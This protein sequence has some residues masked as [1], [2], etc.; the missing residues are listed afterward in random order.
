VIEWGGLQLAEQVHAELSLLFDKVW[1]QDDQLR[2]L[3]AK[4]FELSA[5]EVILANNE[6]D[7]WPMSS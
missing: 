2:S 6:I 1:A 7:A 3:V 4:Y 5:D